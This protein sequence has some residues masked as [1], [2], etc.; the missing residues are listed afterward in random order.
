MKIPFLARLLA[1]AVFLL[2]TTACEKVVDLDLNE[3]GP[4]LYIEGNLADD[5]QP[6]VA[7]LATSVAFTETSQFPPVRGAVVTLSDDAGGL[8][9]LRET[10]PGRYEG[11]T[12]TG[13]SGRRYTLRVE[14][15]GSTWL[16]RPCRP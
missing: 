4:R 13:Q 14:A 16:L 3:A 1:G 10:S 2:L 9:T 7:T 11:A 6:A 15:G 12:I 5:G 8:E